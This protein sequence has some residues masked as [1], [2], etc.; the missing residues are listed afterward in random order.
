MNT[1]QDLFSEQLSDLYS[2][3]TQLVD[4]LPKMA[5]AASSQELREAFEEHLAQTRRHV[6]R[7]DHVFSHTGIPRHQEECEAMKG[8]IKEGEK[9]IQTPGSSAVKDAALIAAAQ[10]VEHYEIAGYGT[11]AEYAGKLGFD[12][13]KDL[14]GETLDEERHTDEKLNGLATGGIIDSGINEAAM[15]Q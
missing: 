9:V 7:L 11:V 1:L 2:A 3:E 10:R 14:L 8:L 12:E 15:Q 4:A 6:E 13:A 5:Q